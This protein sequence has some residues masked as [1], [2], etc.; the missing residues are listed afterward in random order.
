MNHPDQLINLKV[1]ITNLLDQSLTATI[2]GFSPNY[3][4]LAL[5]IISSSSNKSN[6]PKR[7]IFKIVNTSFI[8]SLQVILPTLKKAQ[9]NGSSP[10]TNLSKVDLDA[11]QSKLN[12]IIG[13][14]T[15]QPSLHQASDQNHSVAKKPEI[16]PLALKIFNR[17]STK[18]GVENV[19]WNGNESILVFKEIIVSKPFALNKISH[20]KRSQSSKH[21]NKL[22]IALR[23]TW[24]EVDNNRRGG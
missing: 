5:K 3:D 22:K 1:K 14:R 16:S 11:L 19:E 23:D 2:H 20:S 7:E 4:V 9:N 6:G 12:R 15:R 13:Y 21:I 24:L 8:K 10:A 17:L 18:L